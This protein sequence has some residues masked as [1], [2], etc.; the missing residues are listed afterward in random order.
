MSI[1][2][3]VLAGA[4]A[5]GVIVGGVGV[6]AATAN[7]STPSCGHEC[8][9]IYSAVWGY[10]NPLDVYKQSARVG[11][12]IILFRKSN[13]DPGQDFT[14]SLQGK[15]SDFYALGLVSPGVELH[16]ANDYAY[17]LEYTPYGVGTDLC[18][19]TGST[20]GNGTAVTLQPCG[21][22]S[23]TVWIVDSSKEHRGFAPLINGSDTNFS[24][25]YV[26]SYRGGAAP[27]DM[28]RPGLFTWQETGFSRGQ[29]NDTQLWR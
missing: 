18:V 14:A 17:E 8:V 4:A 24:H 3:K 2:S 20:A 25:P 1:K 26:L 7:A 9:N 10:H 5:A 12:K 16:Y 23:K 21:A 6:A 13:S 11:T 27:T 28:P 29:V 15:V 19:G 22:S